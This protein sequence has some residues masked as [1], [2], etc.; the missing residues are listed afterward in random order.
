V[1]ERR[2]H[3]AVLPAP[4]QKAAVVEE[5]FDTI[6]PRYDLVNRIMT[7]GQ[8]E[9]W[10]R[11]TVETLQLPSWSVVLD[12]ACG[13]GDLCR[14]LADR[15]YRP[16]GVDFSAGML[17]RA[18]TREPL[19]RADA[20]TLPVA[21]GGVDGIVCGFG[22]RNFSDVEAFVGECHRALRS[23]GRV[24]VLET[25]RPASSVVRAAH[26]FYFGRIV[27]RIGAW[28]SDAEA[29]RYLPAST[30]ALPESEVL[31]RQFRSGGFPDVEREVLGLGAI[32]LL[33]GTRA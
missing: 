5:M 18:R 6:A 15:R 2:V 33:V 3:D 7:G 26:G 29:Y 4:D 25:A 32:Q 30:D 23:G 21:A 17:R 8:D 10:R 19:V 27:P 9:R 24:A 22:L 12:V 31:L 28:L 16:V 11:R 14:A 1:T 20:L 13:T